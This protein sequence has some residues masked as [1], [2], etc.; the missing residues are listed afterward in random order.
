M[1]ILGPLPRTKH[2]NR[3][4]LKIS[5]RFSKVTKTVPLRTVTALSVARAFCDHWDHWVYLYGPPLSLLTYNGPQ[6]TVKFF[7]AVCTELRIKKIFT[8]AYHPQTNGQVERFNRT[9][10]ASLRA[11]FS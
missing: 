1:D 6:F 9:I 5:D 4:L 3:F 7:L 11:Y 2:G 8:T 10:I